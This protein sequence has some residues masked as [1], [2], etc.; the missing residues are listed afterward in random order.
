M[1]LF[2]ADSHGDIHFHD[3]CFCCDPSRGSQLTWW[4]APGQEGTL[5]FSLV[6]DSA[7]QPSALVRDHSPER[8][9]G[10]TDPHHL[11]HGASIKPA[12]TC[13][14]PAARVTHVTSRITMPWRIG[15]YRVRT[16]TAHPTRA[17]NSATLKVQTKVLFSVVRIE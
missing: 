2:Y 17:K 12:A 11:A 15:K 16:Q 10:A 9:P 8:P 5:V 4:A 1:Q 14:M 3:L 7:I 13:C 6:D